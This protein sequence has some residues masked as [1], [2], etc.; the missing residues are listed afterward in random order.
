M[1]RLIAFLFFLGFGVI[2]A[3]PLRV[4]TWNLDFNPEAPAPADF[5][6]LLAALK[7]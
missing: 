2:H 7:K 5:K 4:T 6:A 1:R 3:E